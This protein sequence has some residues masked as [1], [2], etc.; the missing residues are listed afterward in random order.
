MTQYP[1]ALNLHRMG[2]RA[3]D[4]VLAL[5]NR[6]RYFV[7]KYLLCL[8]SLFLTHRSCIDVKF[9]IAT[10]PDAYSGSTSYRHPLGIR[11]FLEAQ[12]IWPLL[13]PEY[14]ESEKASHHFFLA[15]TILHELAVCLCSPQHPLW[16][17]LSF[18][19]KSNGSPLAMTIISSSS[20][21]ERL[22]SFSA[23]CPS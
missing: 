8:I 1:S 5:L 21:N 18:M 2:F 15:G 12:S 23:C 9:V 19:M 14:T 13:I 16:S 7:T 3:K 17:V 11:I 6:S 4:A 10:G 22:T 20:R